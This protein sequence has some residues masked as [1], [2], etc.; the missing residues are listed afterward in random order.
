MNYIFE[1]PSEMLRENDKKG[2][3][4]RF[5]YSSQTYDEQGSLPLEK[6]AWVYL[7]YDYDNAKKYNILYLLHGGGVNEDWWLKTFPDTVTILDN[8][9]A[10][11]ICEPCIIVTP[12]YYRGTETDRNGEF[13]TEQFHHELR[14]DLIPAI[15]T[16][17]STYANGDISVE[18]LVKTRNHR[19]FAGLSLG[20][21][22]T[23]RAAFYNNYDLFSWYGPFSGCCGPKGDHAVEIKRITETLENGV[24]NNL[25]LDYMFC[26]NGDQ[27]IAY[28]EHIDIMTNVEKQCAILKR[29]TNYDFFVIPGG[30][31]DMKA[32]QLHLF[33]ALQIFF[34]H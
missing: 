24:K 29:D 10:Q 12:T 9:M 14:K 26:C 19:A 23:Y 30:V 16:K 28:E 20:S 6:S 4:E 1:M 31:H 25:P 7:P 15:E 34:T 17:Y 5:T 21:M 22:T 27:D 32:W 3:V 11:G 33:H 8:M 13:I 18:N 2:T